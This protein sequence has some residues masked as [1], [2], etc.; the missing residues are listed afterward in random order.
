MAQFDVF[1]N[2]NKESAGA[3]P[4]LLEVQSDYLSGF[5]SRVVVPLALSEQIRITALRLHP[6]FQIEGAAVFMMTERLAAVPKQILGAQVTSLAQH[7]DEI[8]AAMDFLIIGF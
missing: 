1:R 8:V 4:F 3:V 6:Q 7:R 5:S 2:P